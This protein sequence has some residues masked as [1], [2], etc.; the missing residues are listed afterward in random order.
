M[1]HAYDRPDFAIPT[2]KIPHQPAGFDSALARLTRRAEDAGYQRVWIL[3]S[4][5]REAFSQAAL[6]ALSSSHITVGTNI[7]SFFSHTPTLLA[8]GALSISEI[9]GGRFILGMGPGGTEII[10]DGHGIPFER[11]LSRAREAVTIARRLLSGERFSFEGSHFDI[12]RD[13]RLRFPPGDDVPIYLSAIN[14]KMLQLA[15]EIADGVILTHIPL[16]AVGSV[17][18]NIEIGA[19]RADRDPSD[20]HLL[21]NLPVGVEE[22]EA[23]FALKRSLCLYLASGTFDWFVGHTEWGPLR[24]RIRDMWWEGRRDEAAHIAEDSFVESFGLGYSE[25]VIR[26][27]IGR[28]LELGIVPIL[29]PY[30]I[31]KGKEDDDLSHLLDLGAQI[32]A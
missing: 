3:E 26:Q 21:S 29:Y 14:P 8:M 18:E 5:D 13:F 16:E 25:D 24:E 31:R 27:R 20:V 23:I 10:R 22:E 12:R 19:R 2:V 6:L 30:G 15:G 1:K 11:P 4:T 17:K 28:Y 32:D 7:V 9:S